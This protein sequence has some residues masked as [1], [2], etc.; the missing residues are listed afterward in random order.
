VISIK[1]NRRLLATAVAGL[2]LVISAV[3]V[4]SMNGDDKPAVTTNPPL[5]ADEEPQDAQVDPTPD[6]ETLPPTNDD[7]DEVPD[8]D[9]GEDQDD[10]DDP[11]LPEDDEDGPGDDDEDDPE[12][13]GKAHGLQTAIQA[14]IKNMEK[15]EM[16]G[17]ST[18]AGLENS[19]QLLTEMYAGLLAGEKESG[20]ANGH[21]KG[22]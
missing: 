15:T 3:M 22:A 6:A 13:E 20:N 19:L 4:A 2:A 5:A 11:E 1:F 14:H 8:D 10:P 16:K 17:K 9:Q 7:P 21:N 18:P 12:D